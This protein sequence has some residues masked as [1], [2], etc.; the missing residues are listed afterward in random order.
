[1]ANMQS[2]D[3]RQNYGLIVGTKH[4]LKLLIKN[5]YSIVQAQDTVWT[6]GEIIGGIPDYYF[7]DDSFYFPKT[8]T[9]IDPAMT[10]N[11]YDFWFASQRSSSDLLVA[12]CDTKLTVSYDGVLSTHSAAIR[13]VVC[14]YEGVSATW[15]ATNNVYRLSE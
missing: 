14:L 4:I 5:L 10:E 6:F 2:G 11:Y 13:P 7:P 15:D 12:R 9:F 8:K 3:Q 1:M